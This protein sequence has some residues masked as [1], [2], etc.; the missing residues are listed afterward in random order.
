MRN[1]LSRPRRIERRSRSE[2]CWSGMS[3]YLAIFGSRAI[4][5]I[6]SSGNTRG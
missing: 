1:A 4:T 5:S 6:S 3:R 2:A